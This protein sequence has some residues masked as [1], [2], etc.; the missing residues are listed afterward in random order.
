MSR[1]ELSDAVRRANAGMHVVT[2]RDAGG[3][4]L[5]WFECASREAAE[6]ECDYFDAHGIEADSDSGPRRLV[7]C[8]HDERLR[9][10]PEHARARAHRLAAKG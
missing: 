4:A 7:E 3:N 6:L 2:I 5:F 1:Q 8:R 9:R 10:R